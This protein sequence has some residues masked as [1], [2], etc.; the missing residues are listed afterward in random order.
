MRS[1]DGSKSDKKELKKMGAADWMIKALKMNP[2]YPHWGPE[3]DYM[4]DGSKYNSETKQCES[5]GRGWGSNIYIDS[6][7]EFDLK[8]DDLNEV[9]NFYFEVNR[10][11]Q[12]CEHC[13]GYGLNPET[14]EIERAWY[15]FE[16]V[17]DKW[18]NDITQH[19]VDAL[20]EQNRLKCDFDEKPTAA[21][22]N[23]WNKGRGLGHDAINRWICVKARAQRE[24][25]Y[26]ECEHCNGQGYI[27]IAD[28]PH[29]ELVLWLLHP[30][31]GAARGVRVR[32]IDEEDFNRA[33][34]YLKEA[35]KRNNDRFRRLKELK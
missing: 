2:D 25:V 28:K 31:K 24:G 20:W 22:V 12:D 16:G 33:V 29:V 9:V 18:C 14:K 8:L 32:N 19:E 30:R 4:G 27:Y 26:G 15:D 7:K 17:G 6:W 11:S 5:S 34:A 13:Q 21:Q 23:E 3:E 1:Y 35:K 10:K